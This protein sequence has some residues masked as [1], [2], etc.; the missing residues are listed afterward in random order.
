MK[1]IAAL[2]I[3]ILSMSWSPAVAQHSHHGSAV[4]TFRDSGTCSTMVVIP[5]KSFTMGSPPSET[6]RKTD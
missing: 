4:K 6:G 3:T 2:A 5:G 1:T